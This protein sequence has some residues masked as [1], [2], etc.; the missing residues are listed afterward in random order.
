MMASLVSGLVARAITVNASPIAAARLSHPH[1]VQ[2]LPGEPPTRRAF[3][4]GV[5]VHIVPVKLPLAHHVP[6]TGDYLAE[7]E[8][9]QEFAKMAVPD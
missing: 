1:T 3:V 4:D 9:Y 8:A 5:S 7:G 2:K 6:I